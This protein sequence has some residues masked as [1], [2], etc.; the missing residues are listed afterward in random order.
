MHLAIYSVQ[1]NM[2]NESIEDAIDLHFLAIRL[3]NFRTPDFKFYF[4][5]DKGSVDYMKLEITELFS[6]NRKC[7]VVENMYDYCFM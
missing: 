3:K 1:R 5:L 6:G 7:F 2:P 4:N